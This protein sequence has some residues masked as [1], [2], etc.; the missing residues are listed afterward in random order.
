MT[1]RALQPSLHCGQPRIP[2]ADLR[3]L[4][5]HSGTPVGLSTHS[6][7]YPAH[8][9][10]MRLYSEVIKKNRDAP[11]GCMQQGKGHGRGCAAFPQGCCGWGSGGVLPS[12]GLCVCL[13]E[14]TYTVES[15]GLCSSK[16][17]KAGGGS[18][19]PQ[20]GGWNPKV[21]LAS[22]RTRAVEQEG[23]RSSCRKGWL[24]EA[25]SSNPRHLWNPSLC[26]R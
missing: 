11:R 15:V 12:A 9:T 5:G 26:S 3:G 22:R 20:L 7:S 8:C 2:G 10:E 14:E 19:D 24:K 18:W 25:F 23:L 4:T 21:F 13:R 16:C 6:R 1:T 17:W